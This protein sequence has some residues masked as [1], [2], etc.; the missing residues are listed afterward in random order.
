MNGNEK[1]WND[2]VVM[3]CEREEVSNWME[4]GQGRYERCVKA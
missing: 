3:D 4:G 1:I 2:I